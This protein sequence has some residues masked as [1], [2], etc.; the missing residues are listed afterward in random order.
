[1][2]LKLVCALAL[3]APAVRA[4]SYGFPYGVEKIRGVSIGGWLAIEVSWFVDSNEPE[5]NQ[6]WLLLS[7][8]GSPRRSL[9]MQMTSAS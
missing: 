4:L 3:A 1:M 2:H 7:S 5:V 9:R 6:H 8:H